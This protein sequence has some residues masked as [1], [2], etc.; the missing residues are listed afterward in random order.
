[1]STT[2][3][4]LALADAVA[5]ADGVAPLNEASRIAIAAGEEP[6]VDRLL[7][8]DNSGTPHALAYAPGDAPVELCV[9]PDRRGAG[10]GTA[11]VRDLLD[12]GEDAF[13][14]HGDLD[15][16]RAIASAVGLHAART[17]LVLSRDADEPLPPEQ[18]LEG[19]T[20]RTWRETDRDEL[21]A[22][23]ARA[24]ADHAEQGAMDS[25]DLAA[26]MAQEWFDPAGLFVAE[27]DG[28]V[29]GFHWT[30]VDPDAHTADGRGV[31]EVYVVGVDPGAQ[32]GGLG[33]ALTLRGLHHLVGLGLGRIDLYVEGDN[34]PALATYYGL[35]FSETARD[36]L[37]AR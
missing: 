33:K 3:P 10:V 34:T 5:D 22:V 7:A 11:L 13:W 25:A 16:A 4:R 24:F 37:Y 17:L 35:G 32:G 19:T 21:I 12:A 8:D 1:M 20:L 28:R 9:R 15:P 26:R 29:V 6:R 23:N 31:G 30:K 36:V 2:D 18:P 14:A 27:R